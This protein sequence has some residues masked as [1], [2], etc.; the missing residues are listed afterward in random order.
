MAAVTMAMVF[1][2][3]SGFVAPVRAAVRQTAGEPERTTPDSYWLCGSLNNT[4]QVEI[5]VQGRLP[6]HH[7]GRICYLSPASPHE[8]HPLAPTH[9]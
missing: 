7:H 4:T 1:R 8:H 5:L 6:T 3:T 9:Y 2:H